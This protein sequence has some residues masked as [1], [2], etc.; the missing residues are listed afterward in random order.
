MVGDEIIEINGKLI[1]GHNENKILEFLNEVNIH[2][3]KTRKFTLSFTLQLLNI[4]V[5]F[6]Y[7]CDK[8]P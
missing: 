5:T 6:Y 2:N 8:R 1:G 3:D 7:L 4:P